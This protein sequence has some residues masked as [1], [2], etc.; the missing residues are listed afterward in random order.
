MRPSLIGLVTAI[1]LATP[2]RA[3]TPPA[4]S[5]QAQPTAQ[6][7]P[8]EPAPAE[9]QPGQPP[10]PPPAADAA[11]PS[12]TPPPAATVPAAPPPTPV[13]SKTEITLYGV[14]ELLAFYD[15]VQNFGGEGAGNTP[16]PRDGTYASD[17]QRLQFSPRGSRFGFRLAAPE[18]S[19]IKL[20]G[21]VEADFVGNGGQPAPGGEGAFY[22]NPTFRIRHV[23]GRISTSVVDVTL[24]QT[25]QLFGFVPSSV[26][27]S[28]MVPGLPG[29]LYTRTSQIR[30]SRVV[31]GDAMNV[32]VAV[33]AA[34]PPQRDS[35]VPDG[36]AGVR[37]T[38]NGRQGMRTPGPGAPV[39]EP[40]SVAVSGIARRFEV[41]EFVAG[42]TDTMSTSGYGAALDFLVPILPARS[43]EDHVGALTLTGEAVYGAGISDQYTGLTA[44]VAFPATLDPEGEMPYV[45]GLDNGMVALSLD[46]TEIEAV[47]WM[48]V[49]GGLQYYVKN[50][51][52]LAAN[53][54]YL[55]SSNVEDL[56]PDAR[57]G[58]VYKNSFFIDGVVAWDI[59]PSARLGLEVGRFQQTY[60]D[61]EEAS[62][63]RVQ[64]GSWYMF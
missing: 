39:I 13:V 56:T 50:N 35:A 45:P 61:D 32:E 54:S 9:Q 38:F 4:A 7:P 23:W 25:W 41:P 44:G 47:K 53:A 11:P 52:W 37:L 49:V 31:K 8:A 40:M 34:R 27:Y 17:H 60:V 42:A 6:P 55:T 15:S 10:G 14:A 20:T 36:Q 48:S 46:G 12:S 64:F 62:S 24:G 58:A 63:M 2:A 5:A 18:F 28:V 59:T 33:A 1:L 57:A 16:I 3:Q 26:G 43:K 51:I 19:G 21:L 22:T 30:L 29:Q